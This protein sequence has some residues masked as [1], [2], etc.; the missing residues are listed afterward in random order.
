ME[1]VEK[2]QVFNN[3]FITYLKKDYRDY[4]NKLLTYTSKQEKGIEYSIS[5][6]IQE[7]GSSLLEYLI[8][9]ETNEDYEEDIDETRKEKLEVMLYDIDNYLMSL[10]PFEAFQKFMNS[11]ISSLITESQI[12]S[13]N[14]RKKII[15]NIFTIQS[16]IPYETKE[17]IALKNALDTLAL[18][19]EERFRDT[20]LYS[21]MNTD[22]IGID[23]K[24]P[25]ISFLNYS[26]DLLTEASII[27]KFNEKGRAYIT[28]V[29]NKAQTNPASDRTGK[30][31]ANLCD[32]ILFNYVMLSLY[33]NTP[34]KLKITNKMLETILFEVQSGTIGK[35]DI[36]SAIVDG[37]IK[38]TESD[39]DYINKYFVDKLFNENKNSISNGDII[40]L[41]K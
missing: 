22:L 7:F 20:F 4:L 18:H 26:E 17:N 33:S 23:G 28:G 3:G 15:D 11:N 29:L 2:K 35:D 39:I 36:I 32:S 1:I 38:F 31:V 19:T 6:R 5:E 24:T 27:S 8:S 16:V 37:P 41:V 40:K 25:L 10:E 9:H 34:E 14:L 21:T 13:N 30:F 12:Y